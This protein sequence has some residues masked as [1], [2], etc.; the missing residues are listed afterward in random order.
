[1]GIFSTYQHGYKTVIKNEKNVL[2][3]IVNTAPIIETVA[4]NHLLTG[5]NTLQNSSLLLPNVFLKLYERAAIF[6]LNIGIT[7]PRHDD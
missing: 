5:R 3:K 2:D 6:L 7:L 1:M 4:N